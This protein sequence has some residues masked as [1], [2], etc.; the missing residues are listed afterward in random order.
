MSEILLRFSQ[1]GFEAWHAKENGHLYSYEVDA[2]TAKYKDAKVEEDWR[3]WQACD[4]RKN[5]DLVAH[6][7]PLKFEW[8]AMGV[9][10]DQPVMNSFNYGHHLEVYL[11]ND[12][13]KWTMK[14]DSGGERG[15]NSMAEAQ[16]RAE[17]I[18][19]NKILFTLMEANKHV[20]I[21]MRSASDAALADKYKTALIDINNLRGTTTNFGVAR[22]IA[23]KALGIPHTDSL[24]P[25]AGKV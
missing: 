23:C 4:A 8:H 15:F 10:C 16:E 21:A 9:N 6:A 13:K 11:S 22:A 3:I 14:V 25:A 17:S 18:V 24:E 1:E 19:R 2:D 20:E 7:K 5:S 12:N